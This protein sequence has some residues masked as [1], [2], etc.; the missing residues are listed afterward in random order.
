[1]ARK[2]ST[3]RRAAYNKY[4]AKHAEERRSANKVWGTSIPR[5]IAEE[6]DLFLEKNR[7]SKVTLIQFGYEALKEYV[8]KQGK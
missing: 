5:P 3:P 2:E 1:M 4:E 7:L 6:M 8:A